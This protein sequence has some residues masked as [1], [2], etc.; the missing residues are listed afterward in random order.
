MF[1]KRIFYKVLDWI[2]L[3]KGIKR[4]Y[5]GNLVRMPTRYFRYFP[6]DYEKENFR[7]INSHIDR[8]MNVLDI[9][10]HIGVMSVV[11][12]RRAGNSGRVLAIEPTPT[13][14]EVLKKTI[15]LNNLSNVE[16]Q[17]LAIAEKEGIMKF[18]ISD[19]EVD[20]SN[21]LVNNHR[22]DRKEESIKVRVTS[23]DKLMEEKKIPSVGFIKIDVEG[24]ELRVLQGAHN[25]LKRHKPKILLAIH[26]VSIRNFD[27]SQ[28][29][30][31]DLVTKHGYRVVANGRELT[32][33]EFTKKEE[34]FDVYLT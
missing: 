30:I 27:D 33:D 14:I 31:W 16:V 13:T 18:Y 15:Q 2:T 32:R 7:F 19:N 29:E 21:S 20:N 25:T 6:A 3:G 10:A 11:F 12:A 9:G 26:P 34:L 1:L 4:N 28:G 8:G 5:E 22:D 23:V 17:P 24:A